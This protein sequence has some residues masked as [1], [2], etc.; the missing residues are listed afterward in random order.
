MWRKLSRLILKV[1]ARRLW[2]YDREQYKE[3]RAVKTFHRTQIRPGSFAYTTTP[4]SYTHLQNG[5]L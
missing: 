5:R 3:K 4:V 1:Y 2:V